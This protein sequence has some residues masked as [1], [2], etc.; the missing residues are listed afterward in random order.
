MAQIRFRTAD[1]RIVTFKSGGARSNPRKP[2]KKVSAAKRPAKKARPSA[3][4]SRRT[5]CRGRTYYIRCVGGRY[6]IKWGANAPVVRLAPAFGKGGKRRERCPTK[7]KPK[8]K[9]TIPAGKTKGDTF[10]R[11]GVKYRVSTRKTPAGGYKRIAVK[12]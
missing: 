8:G 11:K 4:W 3:K 12:V 1:G 7:I 10:T 5:D 9:C 6:E 2:A